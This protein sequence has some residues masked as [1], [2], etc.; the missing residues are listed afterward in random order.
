MDAPDGWRPHDRSS[1]LTEP[2][3]PLFA[4][5]QP[6]ALQLGLRVR[7]AHCNSRGLAH[8]GLIAAL[9][10]NAMGLS[11]AVVARAEG[12]EVRAPVTVS[13]ALDYIDAARE[14]DWL[15]VRPQVLKVGRTLGF[16]ECHV[17]SG[18]RLLAR[19]SATFRIG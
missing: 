10:D 4:R 14:G 1:P 7:R 13:L 2:W 17:C 3:E 5:D 12:I 8:G 9:A 19:G 15:E 11:A 6:R 16:V 18:D